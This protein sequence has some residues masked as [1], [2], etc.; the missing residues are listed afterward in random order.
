MVAL[1]VL[2][3]FRTDALSYLA[4]SGQGGGTPWPTSLA[5]VA[6]VAGVVLGLWRQARTPAGFAATCALS[7]LGFFAFNKQAFCN[8][9][10]FTLGALL[11]V[12]GSVAPDEPAEP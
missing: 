3:P 1:Q 10:Y 7:Y 12:V 6:A 11:V 9:Y 5:F 2:Q 8:Y 4:W